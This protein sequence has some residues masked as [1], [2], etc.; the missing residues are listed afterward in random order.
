MPIFENTLNAFQYKSDKELKRS[1]LLFK[2]VKNPSLVRAGKT[3]LLIARFLH[4][5]VSWMVKPLV[6]KQFCGGETVG[7]CQPVIKK[8]AQYN[9]K[10]ILDYSV[11]GVGNEDFFDRVSEQVLAVIK[12]AAGRP[13]MPF[14]VFKPSGICSHAVLEKFSFDKNGDEAGYRSFIERLDRIFSLAYQH[15]VPVMIDAEESWLQPAVD[16]A[17]MLM[18]EKYNSGQA[19]VYNTLQMYR[20]DRTEFLKN[21]TEAC[22]KK[23]LT[24][25]FKL[26]RGAYIEK[27]RK[28]AEQMKYPSPVYALK[29]ETDDAFNAA[30]MFCLKNIENLSFCLATHNENSCSLLMQQLNQASLPVNDR[31][32]W[33][34]QLFGMSDHISFNLSCKGY[35]VAKYVPY[36]EVKLV[37]PYLIRRAEENTSVKGQTGRELSMLNREILRRK[38]I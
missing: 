12:M 37:M 13:E 36:G 15:K 2:M 10:T 11:E 21:V 14:A 34:A 9:V 28:R 1:R 5:P 3:L 32:I 6:F 19:I 29:N 31:R 24:A 33:F 4:I 16:H 7:E 18:T 25:G 22:R 27:E 20:H 8:L 35:N 30:A 23:N 26:V 38:L 17:A